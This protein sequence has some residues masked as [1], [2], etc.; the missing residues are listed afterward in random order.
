MTTS[1]WIGVAQ[2][3]TAVI[4]VLA[5][6]LI[7]DRDRK[8]ADARAADDRL[9]GREEDQR[10]W[11]LDLLFR[12]ARSVEPGQD[13]RS[14]DANAALF[15]LGHERLP[16]TWELYLAE[17]VDWD[18]DI[19]DEAGLWPRAR[20]ELAREIRRLGSGDGLDRR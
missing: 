8:T 7:A 18:D 20:F 11:E 6:L 19:P 1:D 5:A 12:I 15:A 4:A 17:P 13:D 2:T 10:R 16:A 14:R 9:R 3:S